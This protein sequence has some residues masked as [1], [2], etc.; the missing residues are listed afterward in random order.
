MRNQFIF[1]TKTTALQSRKKVVFLWDTY[2]RRISAVHPSICIPC[3][4]NKF[5]KIISAT[6]MSLNKYPISTLIEVICPSKSG[7]Q[8]VDCWWSLRGSFC[9][10]KK[11]ENF[12][13]HFLLAVDWGHVCY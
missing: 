10:K 13:D 2:W 1:L 8:V 5:V 9:K 6:L 7:G 4:S 11:Q 3:V 12:K